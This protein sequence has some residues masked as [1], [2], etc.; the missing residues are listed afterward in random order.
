MYPSHLSMS[1]PNFFSTLK[2]IGKTE[3]RE[4]IVNIVNKHYMH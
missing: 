2:T 1:F 3:H 4:N